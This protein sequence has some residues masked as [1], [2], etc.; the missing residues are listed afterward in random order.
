MTMTQRTTPTP[1]PGLDRLAPYVPGSAKPQGSQSTRVIKLSSNEGAL[2]PSPAAVAAIQQSVEGMHRY[3]DAA[4]TALR[5]ALG[6]VH[7]LD[8]DRIVLGNGS[9]DLLTLLT[10][11]YAGPG[12]TV[13]HSAHGFLMYPICAHSVGAT[14]IS[15]PEQDLTADVDAVVAA[16]R[17]DT[18]IV[19]LANPNNPTGSLLNQQQIR[20]LRDGLPE[21]VLLV[22]DAAYA[23][24]VDDPAYDPGTGL[25][26]KTEN[27]VMTRTFSKA[28][29]MG[30]MRLGWCYAP[31]AIVDVL[32]RIR[33]PF[34][35]NLLAQ[36]AGL[37]AVSDTAFLQQAV[38]HNRT[39]RSWTARRLK[40]LGLTVHP[41][42]TN[43]LLVEFPPGGA[44]RA[45]AFLQARGIIVRRMDG[46][47]L[48]ECLRITIGL[49]DEMRAL[50]GALADFQDAEAAA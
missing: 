28:Y 32:N 38:H 6:D 41:S 15:V 1:R 29:G 45:D 3:P 27:T 46:Y 13:L 44:E 2:G 14:P 50:I 9:D 36:A 18:K 8:P 22:L 40:D 31:A 26:E 48:P 30:G 10:R 39:W 20:K 35:V 19:F 42:A 25:V 7:G 12:D 11:A 21:S 33:D 17:A 16:V 37:A 24:Y 5:R 23:E 34:N 47:G 49:E 43:F 4:G